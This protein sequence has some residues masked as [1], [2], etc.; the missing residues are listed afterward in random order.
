MDREL[1]IRYLIEFGLHG[2]VKTNEHLVNFR[3]HPN[4]KTVSEQSGFDVED[5]VLFEWLFNF[6]KEYYSNSN[7][8]N[9]LN[10]KHFNI[11]KIINYRYYGKILDLYFKNSYEEFD[12]HFR[13]INWK[14]L[15]FSENLNLINLILRKKLVPLYLKEIYHSLF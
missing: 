15:S 2:I 8:F 3:M 9:S 10:K 14:L 7:N 1:W 5:K 6:L 11:E 4:S 13:I 12:E